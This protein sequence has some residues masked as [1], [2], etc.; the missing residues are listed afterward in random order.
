[1]MQAMFLSSARPFYRSS[2]LWSWMLL[3]KIF[4][5]HLSRNILNVGI[6]ESVQK[7]QG[8][9]MTYLEDI[10]SIFKKHSMSRLRIPLMG[11]ECTLDIIRN[12]IHSMIDYNDTIFR[13]ILSNI[14]EKQKELLYAIAKE[15]EAVQILSASFIKRHSLASASSVQTATKSYWKKDIITEVNKVYSVTDKLFAMWI[16]RLYGENKVLL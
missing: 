3:I 12:A 5:W 14:P 7:M 9:S 15:G 2:M 16:N 11:G 4:T 13:E 1:M 6:A 8:R 10:H